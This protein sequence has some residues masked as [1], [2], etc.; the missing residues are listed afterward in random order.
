MRTQST[1]KIRNFTTKLVDNIRESEI[2]KEVDG[3]KLVPA[4]KTKIRLIRDEQIKALEQV[5]RYID[6]HIHTK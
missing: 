3:K 2:P 6:K 5:V 4:Q 1:E